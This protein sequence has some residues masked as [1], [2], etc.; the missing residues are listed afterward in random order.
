M[1]TLPT[2]S[3]RT[4]PDELGQRDFTRN[5]KGFDPAEV[6]AH[7]GKLADEIRR[8]RSV[9]QSLRDEVDRLGSSSTSGDLDD[10][11][12]AQLIGDETARVLEAARTAST[13]IRT[14]AEENGARLVREAQERA[15]ELTREAEELRLAATREADELVGSA[16]VASDEMMSDARRESTELR[17]TADSE[18]RSTRER[19]NSLLAEKT[20]E[21]EAESAAIRAGAE[22]A[23]QEADATA[24]RTRREADEY[25][26][27]TR[28]A[29]DTHA[30]E[31]RSEADEAASK[32]RNDATEHARQR[33]EEAES[34]A[35]V[36]V[37]AAREHGR[38]M[39]QEAKDARERMLRDLAERRRTARQQLEALRAGREAMLEAF[40]RAR[41]SFDLATDTVTDSIGDARVAADEAARNVAGDL[42]AEVA[43]LDAEIPGSDL[44]DFAPVEAPAEPTGAAPEEPSAVEP[45]PDAPVAEH[46]AME[47]PAPTDA[48]PAEGTVAEDDEPSHLRL[49]SSGP[50]LAGIDDDLDLDDDDDDEIEDGGADGGPRAEDIFARLRAEQAP[51]SGDAIVDG[52]AVVIDLKPDTDTDADA[53]ADGVVEAEVVTDADAVADGGTPGWLDRRDAVLVDLERSLTRKLKRLLSDHENGALDRARRSKK[54]V[55][56]DEVVGSVESF[57]AVARAA[58]TDDL[59]EAVT[60]GS[61]FLSDE[62]H[63]QFVDAGAVVGAMAPEITEWL[64]VT[65]R[66]RLVRVVGVADRSPRGRDELLGSLRATYRELKSDQVPAIGVDLLTLAFN[67]GIL[68]SAMAG[69]PHCWLVDHGGLPC[70]DAEDNHLAGPTPAGDEF[71][72]GDVVPPAHPGCRCL[73]APPAQ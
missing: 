72:T 66:D 56:A 26:T 53:D 22:A 14:K 57:E 13:E 16:R 32:I 10:A 34:A 9:E 68:G 73:L 48:A 52:G 67:K 65:V 4:D 3:D 19:A 12:L 62:G 45:P 40:T 25:A 38:Q 5:R 11:N 6:R 18:A 31:V 1:A 7:V 51:E 46:P 36:V 24:E 41:D 58:L 35:E 28:S 55:T 15:T 47:P 44:G 42:D 50:G 70:P 54:T 17:E 64:T 63:G 49:V 43:E 27:V 33:A 60:S 8:L 61:V 2:S 59:V 20:A 71:P 37:E 69:T 23:K 30:D 29:A 39:V 21:A